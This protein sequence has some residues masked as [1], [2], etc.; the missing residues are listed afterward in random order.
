MIKT[1]M[2]ASTKDPIFSAMLWNGQEGM[3]FHSQM[4]SSTQS[5]WVRAFLK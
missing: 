3:V 4:N 5:F 1:M 2:A